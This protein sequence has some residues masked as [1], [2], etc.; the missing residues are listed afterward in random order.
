MSQNKWLGFS[1]TALAA[2]AAMAVVMPAMAQEA[3]KKADQ[4]ED[5][6]APRAKEDTVRLGTIVITGEGGKLGT[7]QMLNEDAGKARSTVTRAAI[8]KDRATGNPF[9]ALAMLP[10]VSTFN[11][12]AT[13]LFGGGLT[14][15]GFGADQMGFTVN[16]VPVNDSGNFA[17]YPQEYADQ[18]NL[19][20]Q[21]IS[22]GSPD[23]DSPHAGATGGNVGITSCDPED[24]RR[25]RVSQTLGDLNLTRTFVRYDTGRFLNNS[26]KV[27]L[28]YSHTQADKWKGEGEAKKD[29]IDAA[30]RWDINADNTILGSVLYN[31]AVNNSF[32][33]LSAA[34]IAS[35]YYTDYSNTFAGHAA[36]S[37]GTGVKDPT[38]SPNYWKLANNPFENAVVS[39]SGSFKLAEA[40][41]L[42]VQPYLWWGFGN[43]GWS[44]LAMSES[45]FLDLTKGTNTG[46]KD[47]NGDGDTLDTVT[48]ARASVTRTS[49]PG[50]T[51]EVNTTLGNHNLRVGVWFERAE[52]KQTQPIVSID[53]AG[54]PSDIWLQNGRIARPDGSLYQGRDWDTIST[55]YQAYVNDNWSFD[56]D[57]GSLSVGLR[58]PHV[59]RDVTNYANE[60]L[61]VNYNIN[62]S[63]SELLPQ[64]ALRYN[65]APAHQVFFS[66]AKNFRAPANFA[67]TGSNI[68]VTNGVATL[69][70]EAKPETS[71]MTDLG[72]RYQSKWLSLSAT[73]FNSAFKNRQANAYDPIADKSTYQNAG[74][75]NNRGLELEAGTGKYK[76]FS[77]YASLT[78]QKSEIK[79]DLLIAKATLKNGGKEDVYLPLSGKQ[80]TLTP[81]RI[82]ATSVQYEYGNFYGRLKVKRT[83]RQAA[84]MIND[85]WIPTYWM[86]DFDAGYN[87]GEVSF[88]SNVQLRLNVSNIGNAK[89]RNLSSGS[90][91]N[92]Q[93]YNTTLSD[94]SAYSVGSNGVFYYVGAPRFA[95]ISLSADF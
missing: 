71:V 56:N 15:R 69:V 41:Y 13:G 68:A 91:T 53:N 28:S 45:G 85:E 52:H 19:C 10:G 61:G 36:P 51:T 72:Y 32:Y 67:F 1:K 3:K 23:V 50:V 62:K 83:G 79:N 5:D 47:L 39:V 43:G 74:D 4:T 49:R 89:Y 25:V 94:G 18:E 29:H 26:A 81:E 82:V 14:V 38:Q 88:A 65:L 24:K 9:Q 95:S 76:G 33:T 48:V 73:L 20:T 66:M 17:V 16:G 78:M 30:F 64:L 42:K 35:N 60:T 6:G 31:R 59:K 46:K 11:H 44:Q 8:D 7:G 80:F 75:V 84:T 93:K 87:F 58:A 54:N 34:Q 37:P 21:S 22:Q 12:D 63:Y 55:A 77:A 2:A 90:V 86:A 27:F 92:A 70:R 40:T 57:N